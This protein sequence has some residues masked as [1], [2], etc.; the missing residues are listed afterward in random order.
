MTR[1]NDEL[2]HETNGGLDRHGTLHLYQ[3][4]LWVEQA[5]W[6][7]LESLAY[8]P[9]YFLHGALP[10]HGLKDA[11]KKQKNDR[12]MEKKMTAPTNLLCRGFP[13][14]LGIFLNTLQRSVSTTS[15]T[16]CTFASSS[17]PLI[18]ECL[19]SYGRS[20]G[21]PPKLRNC[22][23]PSQRLTG[24]PTRSSTLPP[25][26]KLAS[27]PLHTTRTPLSAV[28]R[29]ATNSSQPHSQPR[30]QPSLTTDQVQAQLGSPIPSRLPS[31]LFDQSPRI[32]EVLR[33]I[34]LSKMSALD[35]RIQLTECQSVASQSHT[36]LQVEVDLYRD[37]KH[38]EGASKLEFKS[39]TKTL[40]DSKWTVESTKRDSEKR[41]KSAQ[42]VHDYA[43]QRM[44]HLDNEIA[45]LQQRLLDDELSVRQT[46]EV[47]SQAEQEI[48]D[49][50]AY[51]RQG[52]RSR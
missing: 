28:D 30:S 15:P 42:N 8:V 17:E 7:D 34:A 41:L 20:R 43:T 45:M 11:T 4:L 49:A 35:L 5:H 29:G 47:V 26:P 22:E 46:K 40:E 19:P 2:T 37:R 32:A 36:S 6:D 10:W 33:E 52:N 27:L 12:I 3:Y 44:V 51:K 25:L 39:C 16:I 50:L 18:E 14:E 23:R 48:T 38:Q 9:M 24:L 13:N 1:R 21:S 31:T